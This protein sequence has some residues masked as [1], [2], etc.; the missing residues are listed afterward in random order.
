MLDHAIHLGKVMLLLGVANGAPIIARKLLENRFAASLDGGTCWP[1][2]GRRLLGE[3]KTVRGLIASIVATSLAAAFLGIDWRV[4]A[5]FAAA[6][7]TGDVLSSF[8]KRR[9]GRKV[10]SQ[11]FGLDQIPESLLPL[12]LFRETF[13][14]GGMDLFVLVAL[15]LILELWLSR[16]LFRLNI[17]ERP[18]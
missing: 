15:F 17:R 9:L 13:A 8:V 5:G 6:A 18:Y 16:L 2:D 3:S 1:F 14:L 7:M 11:F 10:H 4:A 12:L